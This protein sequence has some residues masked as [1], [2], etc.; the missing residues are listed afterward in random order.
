MK[1]RE[2]VVLIHPD[3]EDYEYLNKLIRKDTP[4]KIYYDEHHV[5]MCPNEKCLKSLAD[6]ETDES[7]NFKYCPNCG[8]KIKEEIK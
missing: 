4:K 1:N 6:Y 3:V 7:L 2:F 5:P 8:Q